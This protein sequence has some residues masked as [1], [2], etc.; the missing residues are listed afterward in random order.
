MNDSDVSHFTVLEQKHILGYL[1][2]IIVCTVAANRHVSLPYHV[3]IKHAKF[4][5][6]WVI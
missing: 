5:A 2:S 1:A 6:K 3:T 4:W